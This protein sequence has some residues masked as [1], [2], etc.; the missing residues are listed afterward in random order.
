[1]STSTISTT[2]KLERPL[3]SYINGLN[4]SVSDMVL[5]L[6]NSFEFECEQI[7]TKYPS[8]LGLGVQ[9]EADYNE[10][11]DEFGRPYVNSIIANID[12]SVLDESWSAKIPVGEVMGPNNYFKFVPIHHL[13]KVAILDEDLSEALTTF[14]NS[15][16]SN[17]LFAST[18]AD[19]FGTSRLMFSYDV[20]SK[21]FSWQGF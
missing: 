17:R 3:S 9:I 5:N 11:N 8:F 21:N 16:N 18:I 15:I 6:K 7:H 2:P 12:P 19:H 14:A 1:M 20:P 4:N 10:D 13:Y